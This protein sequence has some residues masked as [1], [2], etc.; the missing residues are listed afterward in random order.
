MNQAR[1]GSKIHLF[2]RLFPI[3]SIA[4][5][6]L[7]QDVSI[8]EK[9]SSHAF[10][11]ANRLANILHKTVIRGDWRGSTVAEE[12]KEKYSNSM[13]FALLRI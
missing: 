3:V 1:A 9:Y 4:N 2:L 10:A 7:G 6:A 8:G 11:K 13:H 12:L 5:A